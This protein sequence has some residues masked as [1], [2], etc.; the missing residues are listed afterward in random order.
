[1]HIRSQIRGLA[2]SRVSR[3]SVAII[4]ATLL[5]TATP[6]AADPS[7]DDG[8]HVGNPHCV[9]SADPSA[10]PEP[11]SVVLFGSALVGA[12]GYGLVRLRARR[13]AKR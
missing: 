6:A 8:E 5:L 11:D 9:T 2:G 13:R 10:T 7:C 1:M 3:S 4:V 12:A